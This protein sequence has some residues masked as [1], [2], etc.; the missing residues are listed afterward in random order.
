MGTTLDLFGTNKPELMKNINNIPGTV[1]HDILLIDSD[2][3]ARSS[4]KPH[5]KVFKW[6]Q[7]NWQEQRKDNA[8]FAQ[9]CLNEEHT[10]SL[11]ENYAAIDQHLKSALKK[12]TPSR[13]T[14]TYRG[15]PRTWRGNE[16]GSR[17]CTTEQRRPLQAWAQE[18]LQRTPEGAAIAMP[19]KMEIYQKNLTSW[20]GWGQQWTILE[21]HQKPET[22]PCGSIT[23]KDE[24]TAASWQHHQ[25]RYHRR[26][27]QVRFH[28]GLEWHP[29]RHQTVWTITPPNYRTYHPRRRHTKTPG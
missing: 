26:S 18:T 5:R 13:Y 14:R 1:D 3:Q 24:R 28:Q 10:R 27:V 21:L 9:Q 4:K 2:I 25:M 23:T 29:S 19:R 12:H 20:T 6:S 16:N 22:G 7:G 11:E 15:S 8:E 17:N